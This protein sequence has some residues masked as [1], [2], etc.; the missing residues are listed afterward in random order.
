VI[1]ASGWVWFALGLIWGATIVVV[2]SIFRGH[3]GDEERMSDAWL[4]RQRREREGR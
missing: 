4:E 2:I 3:S 1:A